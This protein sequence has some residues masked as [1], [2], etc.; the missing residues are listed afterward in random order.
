MKRYRDT[1]LSTDENL[2]SRL[3]AE[4]EMNFD[5]DFDYIQDDE[6][7]ET[8]EIEEIDE[9]TG[10]DDDEASE[11]LEL[12]DDDSEFEDDDTAELEEQEMEVVE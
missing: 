2:L 11:E 10:F 6:I 12:I 9:M 4:N 5:D 8:E 1:K 3:A 7:D